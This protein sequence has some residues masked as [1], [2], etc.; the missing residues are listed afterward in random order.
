MCTKSEPKPDTRVFGQTRL[1][2]DPKSKSPTRHC[3]IITMMMIGTRMMNITL[4]FNTILTIATKKII[5]RQMS[6]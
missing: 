2:P 1:E 4:M 6:G 5:V 3:L